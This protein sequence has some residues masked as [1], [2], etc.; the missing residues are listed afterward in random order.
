MSI[1][2]IYLIAALCGCS[3]LSSISVASESAAYNLQKKILL[4]PSASFVQKER[5]KQ[6]V[7]IYESMKLADVEMAMDT[8]FERVENMMFIKT[9]L[10][11][12]IAYEGKVIDDEC[13][14]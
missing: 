1:R 5:A 6:S 2:S 11:E 10:P 14:Y 9:R 8:H 3:I 4:D 7:F 12:G 13:D